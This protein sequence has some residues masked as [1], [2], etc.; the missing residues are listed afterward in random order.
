M[1]RQF[2]NALKQKSIVI[3]CDNTGKFYISGYG[4]MGMECIST[5]TEESKR[6]I[7]SLID[8]GKLLEKDSV[9]YS[10]ELGLN[11]KYYDYIDL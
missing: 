4:G 5:A 1:S 10:P 6:D 3:A 2:L 8:E 7:L 11:L 9:R